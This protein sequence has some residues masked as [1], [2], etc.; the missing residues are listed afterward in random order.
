MSPRVCVGK[1][2]SGTRQ[3]S[4]RRCAE[5]PTCIIPLHPHSPWPGDHHSLPTSHSQGIDKD[6]VLFH[7]V[8]PLSLSQDGCGQHLQVGGKRLQQG[9]VASPKC[10]CVRIPVRAPGLPV[11]VG[12]VNTREPFSRLYVSVTV[13]H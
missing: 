6:G 10:L 12:V 7:W 8:T 9:K 4:A 3:D 13:K 5:D 1:A 11:C 2:G